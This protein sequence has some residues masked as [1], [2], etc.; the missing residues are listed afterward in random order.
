MGLYENEDIGAVGS[1]SNNVVNYQQVKEQYS[2]VRE[3][4]DFVVRNNVEMEYPYENKS[5][6]VGFAMLIKRKAID[7][8]VDNEKITN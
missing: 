6:L 1:V 4:M 2:T 3:W 8:L 5:W 7:K